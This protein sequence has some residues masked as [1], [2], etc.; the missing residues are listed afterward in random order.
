M[1]A[2]R[3]AGD[4]RVLRACRRSAVGGAG[5]AVSSIIRQLERFGVR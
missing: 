1:S 3:V 4:S 2:D 5:V